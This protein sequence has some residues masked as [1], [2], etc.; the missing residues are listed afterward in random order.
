METGSFSIL[1]LRQYQ[2]KP[3]KCPIQGFSVMN[4]RFHIINLDV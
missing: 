1:N 4:Y 3:N 2:D